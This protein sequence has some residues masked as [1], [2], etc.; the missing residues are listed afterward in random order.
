MVKN[1]MG[2]Q[3]KEPPGAPHVAN[4]QAQRHNKGCHCKKSGCLKKYCECFQAGIFCSEICKCVE[5]KNYQVQPSGSSAW[6][7]I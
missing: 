4:A 7:R 6:R 3:D 2:M 5:C 1:F